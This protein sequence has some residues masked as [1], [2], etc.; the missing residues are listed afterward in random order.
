MNVQQRNTN[1]LA[2]TASLLRP[3]VA[4]VK[5][6]ATEIGCPAWTGECCDSVDHP[7]SP[8]ECYCAKAASAV[9]KLAE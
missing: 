6:V 4:Q 2:L 1:F 8:T 5:A 3:S 9:L 7:R